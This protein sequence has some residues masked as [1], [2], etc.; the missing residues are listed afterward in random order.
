MPRAPRICSQ[1]GCPKTATRDGRCGQHQRPAWQGNRPMTR[2]H[3]RWAREVLKRDDYTCRRCGG[4]AT[5]ADHI[6]NRA[7]APHLALDVANGQALCKP[8][9]RAKTQA[10]SRAGR[11]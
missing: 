1:P 2:G 6:V 8:C 7:V 11:Q 3:A 10:E 5:E 4:V 9:H